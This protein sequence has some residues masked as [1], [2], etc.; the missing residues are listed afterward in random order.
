MKQIVSIALATLALVLTLAP[1]SAATLYKWT[2]KNGV[3]HY[4]DKPHEG[5]KPVDLPGLSSFSVPSPPTRAAGQNEAEPANPYTDFSITSP[6]PEE[7]IQADN[8]QVPVTV[9][10]NPALRRGQSLVYM[11]DSQRA[12]STDATSITLGNVNRGTHTLKVMVVNGS[13]ETI[14]QAPA[15]TFHVRHHSALHKKN[16]ANQFPQGPATNNNAFRF[17]TGPKPPQ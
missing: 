1:A 17:P 12:G 16:P 11:L 9:A 3:V 2:D 13:G 6:K 5:A 14:A 8:G 7:T 10:I 15:V 4:S